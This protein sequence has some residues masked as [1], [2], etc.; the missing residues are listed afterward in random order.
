MSNL[1]KLLTNNVMAPSLRMGKISR[2]DYIYGGCKRWK[3]TPNNSEQ[4]TKKK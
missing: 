4:V 3:C 1:L 2:K